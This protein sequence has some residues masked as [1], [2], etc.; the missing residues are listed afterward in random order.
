LALRGLPQQ[1]QLAQRFLLEHPQLWLEQ[2][3]LLE[4]HKLLLEVQMSWPGQLQQGLHKS[5][6]EQLQLRQGLHKSWAAIQLRLCLGQHKSWLELH[7][8]SLELHKSWLVQHMS[9]LAQHMSCL[10]QHMLC[11]LRMSFHHM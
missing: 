11:H 6:L 8:S 5:C 1:C 9:W 3:Q 4:Q 2:A 7:K 10:A